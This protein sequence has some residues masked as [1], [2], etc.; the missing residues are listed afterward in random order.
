MA[1]TEFLDASPSGSNYASDVK[2]RLNGLLAYADLHE[3]S[4]SG[5]R[6]P[7]AFQSAVA[8]PEGPGGNTYYDDNA[9]SAL[10]LFGAY[11]LT[12]NATDLTLAQDTF[13][14][15]VTG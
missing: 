6:Q 7:R 5:T 10:D 13:N 8:R 4:P 11:Q 2:A 3:V 14:F 9:W 12:G 15:V 1:G